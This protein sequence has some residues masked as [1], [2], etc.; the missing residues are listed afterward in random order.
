MQHPSSHYNRI[1]SQGFNKRIELRAHE[2][3]HVAEHQGRTKK[4]QNDRSR[5]RRRHKVP[6]IAGCS[7]FTRKN[8]RFRAPASSPKQ[9]PCNS[10]AASTISASQS[11]HAHLVTTSLGHHLPKAPLPPPFVMYWCVMQNITT[12]LVRNS[13]DCFPTSFD[14][15]T[16]VCY[17]H[18]H[19]YK[20][21]HICIYVCMYVFMYVCMYLCMYVSIYVCLSVCMYVCMFVC[22]CIDKYIHIQV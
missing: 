10:H 9:T 2:Q 19:I 3:P 1:C 21:I 17:I 11:H 14:K 5:N 8:T 4:H 13:E 12:L 18:M 6:F 7:H 15:Y 22:M 20:Y 16:C